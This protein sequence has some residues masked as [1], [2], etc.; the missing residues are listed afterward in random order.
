[1]LIKDLMSK[2]K[3]YPQDLIVLVDGPEEGY[4]DIA[5]STAKVSIAQ[6]TIYDDYDIPISGKYEDSQDGI[7][8]LILSRFQGE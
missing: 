2:L 4:D 6:E 8:V 3:E 5:V 7:K 1:M